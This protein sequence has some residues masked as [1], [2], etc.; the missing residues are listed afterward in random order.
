MDCRP[1]AEPGAGNEPCPNLH[2]PPPPV[3]HQE[4]VLLASRPDGR[5][6]IFLTRTS[7]L[8]P[9][10]SP[11]A[12][13]PPCSPAGGCASL[14]GGTAARP[15]CPKPAMPVFWRAGR[16]KHACG[17]ELAYLPL[18][19]SFFRVQGR[20]RMPSIHHI[21]PSSFHPWRD[22]WRSLL[23]ADKNDCDVSLGWPYMSDWGGI[24]ARIEEISRQQAAGMGAEGWF[25]RKPFRS[26]YLKK[27]AGKNS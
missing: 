18:L 5:D 15:H 9:L 22:H 2:A 12:L 4:P 23:R 21:F 8:P 11:S 17:K 10:S 7:L 1:W 24:L 19:F 25:W 27:I 3:S 14:G 26:V 13:L 6:T 20:G 16:C